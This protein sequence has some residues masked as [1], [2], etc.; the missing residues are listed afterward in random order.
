[1]NSYEPPAYDTEGIPV[2][3]QKMLHQINT[4]KARINEQRKQ[5][6]AMNTE[7]SALEKTFSKY[8]SK[9]SRENSKSSVEKRKRKPSGFAS[10]TEVSDELCLFMNKPTG[11]LVSRTETSRFLSKYISDNKLFN[12][13]NKSIIM[14]DEVLA[15]LLGKEA[16]G[17]E[18]TY[19]TIQKYINRHF[20]KRDKGITASSSMEL[21]A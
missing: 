20:I 16:V 6:N 11:S 17:T 14:P 8:A 19:F 15:S 5:T 2:K 12:E 10:P 9:V 13:S 1:V 3:L 7:V 18:I 21:N 4:L